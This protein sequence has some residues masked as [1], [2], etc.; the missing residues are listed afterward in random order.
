MIMTTLAFASASVILTSVLYAIARGRRVTL[1]VTIEE[2]P[3]HRPTK[4]STAR[5]N[6]RDRQLPAQRRT[7]RRTRKLRS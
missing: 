6:R 1:G 5:A 7:A 4:A 3:E 2:A